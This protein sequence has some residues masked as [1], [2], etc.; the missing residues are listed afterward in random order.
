MAS[1][2]E[3]VK[4]FQSRSHRSLPFKWKHLMGVTFPEQN[5]RV[6]NLTS[7]E[8]G[9]LRAYERSLLQA[10]EDPF[11]VLD[12]IIPNWETFAKKAEALKNIHGH[13]LE[14]H[15]G[16]LLAH[17]D[18]AVRFFRQSIATPERPVIQPR[19][20]PSVSKEKTAPAP[21][22]EVYQP[23]EEEIAELFATLDGQ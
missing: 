6:K 10:G 18:V 1:A 13:P 3:T 8:L 14:P 11:A 17:C 19:Q 7:K 5:H 9:Q 22:E 20:E 23:S 4:A 16:F 2:R 21:K 12:C 15:I